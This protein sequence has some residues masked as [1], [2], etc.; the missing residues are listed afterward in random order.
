MWDEE[1]KKWV[2]VDEDN[3]QTTNEIKPPP[4]MS[5]LMPAVQKPSMTQLPQTNN[6]NSSNNNMPQGYNNPMSYNNNNNM[7]ASSQS[8]PANSNPQPGVPIQDGLS[9]QPNIFKLQKSRSK[10]NFWLMSSY[11]SSSEVVVL[12][13]NI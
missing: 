3:N 2:N 1:K 11:Q 8:M 7:N 6:S 4:K 13:W 10:F 12:F 9:Q 5:D